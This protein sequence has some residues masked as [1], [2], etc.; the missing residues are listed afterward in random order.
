MNRC[1]W[2]KRTKEKDLLACS[3]CTKFYH[4]RCLELPD[5]TLE[6]IKLYDIAKWKCPDCKDCNICKTAGIFV[7]IIYCG[8]NLGMCRTR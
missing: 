7:K 2:C 3:V 6:K 5:E 8:N 4:F 1:A